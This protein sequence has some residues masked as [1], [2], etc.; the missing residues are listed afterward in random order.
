MEPSLSQQRKSLVAILERNISQPPCGCR[1]AWQWG[2]M[3]ATDVLP[4]TLRIARITLCTNH[5]A[6]AAAQE[7]LA[8][9]FHQRLWTRR[10]EAM[11]RGKATS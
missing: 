8:R 4:G 10:E 1:V 7:R 2:Y 9:D 5:Q 11:K 6:D 3:A